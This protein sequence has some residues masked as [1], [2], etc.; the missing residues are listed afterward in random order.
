MN[1]LVNQANN[2]LLNELVI[3]SSSL[4][5]M[6]FSANGVVDVVT[7]LMDPGVKFK[8]PAVDT[9]D[10]TSDALFLESDNATQINAEVLGVEKKN[11]AQG[12]PQTLSIDSCPLIEQADTPLTN[13]GNYQPP[14]VTFEKTTFDDVVDDFCNNHGDIGQG[15][16]VQYGQNDINAPELQK[17][18][19]Y[20]E[21]D[22]AQ[23]TNQCSHSCKTIF[24]SGFGT[25]TQCRYDSHTM[26]QK[27]SFRLMTVVQRLLSSGALGRQQQKKRSSIQCALVVMT[28]ATMATCTKTSSI[29]FARAMC[30]TFAKKT[31]KKDDASKFLF[32][33]T[34]EFFGNH[35]SYSMRASW[36]DGCVLPNGR[37]EASAQN[38]LPQ[39]APGADELEQI[40]IGTY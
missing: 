31:I 2:K 14:L 20:L 22:P 27:G 5:M 26:A 28:M 15:V 4:T 11:G 9:G 19:V 1:D 18:N 29:S 12:F 36:K 35:M 39:G 10:P 13:Y 37:S 3:K 23:N 6:L 25:P 8:E 7:Q 30:D 21:W 33:E 16:K 32:W 34:N 38:P 24:K 40:G 17:W